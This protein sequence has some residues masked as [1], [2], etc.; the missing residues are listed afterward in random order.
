MA[1][2]WMTLDLAP[3]KRGEFLDAVRHA[4]SAAAAGPSEVF[5]YEAIGAPHRVAWHARWPSEQDLDA[6]LDGPD[7]RAVRGAARVLGVDCAF[8]RVGD[9]DPGTTGDH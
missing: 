3:G 9:H 2:L 7:F 5:V 4:V 1:A 8:E 6:F